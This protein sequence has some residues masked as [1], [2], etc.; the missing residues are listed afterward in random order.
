M[1][2]LLNIYYNIF[3]HMALSFTINIYKYLKVD[4]F[5]EKKIRIASIRAS[6]RIS[7]AQKL[8]YNSVM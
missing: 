2:D 5:S 4:G 3:S 1:N 7:N 8:G 6:S